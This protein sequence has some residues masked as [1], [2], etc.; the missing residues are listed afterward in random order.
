[1]RTLLT[2]G[3]L[4]MLSTASA[5]APMGAQSIPRLAVEKYTLPNGLE[6]IL[7][8]DHSTPIVAVNTWYHVG[9]GDEQVGRTGFAHLFEHIMFMGSAHVPTGAF[10]QHLESAGATVREVSLP[11]TKYA[12][13]AYYVIA[14]AEASS[15]LARYDGVRY[16]HRAKDVKQL[17]ELYERSR[18]EGFGPEVK[19]RIMLGTFALS[20]GYHDAYYVKAQQVRTLIRRDF[21]SV[22]SEVDVVLSATSPVCAW[23]LGEKSADPLQMYLMDVLTLPCSLAG[24]PGVSV[25]A[26]K[27]S[28]GL[29][30][31]A[32]LIGRPF[33]E[34]TL[35]RAAK[36][37]EDSRDLKH[38][39]PSL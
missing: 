32:Q 26:G 6:V 30:I 34:A 15:N 12:L 29:P 7:H 3:S 19:R 23:K 18:A 35:L 11:H 38:W 20:A 17:R 16:G 36:V 37:I 4:V 33:D 2:F 21:E 13:A 22:S 8:E 24:L 31:G 28:G 25:P 9:S 10:D 14:P 5:V 27:S 39:R 1:M